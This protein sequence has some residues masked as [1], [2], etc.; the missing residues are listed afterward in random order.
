[1]PCRRLRESLTEGVERA[2]GHVRAEGERDVE[3]IRVAPAE[4]A[5]LA[6]GREEGVEGVD[7]LLGRCDADEHA[8]RPSLSVR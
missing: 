5:V 1:M 6:A 7:D 4:V 2:F 8:H 3:L